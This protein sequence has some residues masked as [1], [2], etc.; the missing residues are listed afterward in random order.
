MA[1]TLIITL[2][3]GPRVGELIN[4]K[5]FSSFCKLLQETAIVLKFVR[6]VRARVLGTSNSTHTD[7]HNGMDDIDQATVRCS[8]SESHSCD[9]L[10]MI[11]S[12]NEVPTGSVP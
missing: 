5:D 6:L 8:C 12:L 11:N 1:H 2:A 7:A 3:G 10:K 9:C 4:C